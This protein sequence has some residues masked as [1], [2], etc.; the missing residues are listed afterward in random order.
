[1]KSA[2]KM[3]RWMGVVCVLWTT[4]AQAVT[5]AYRNDVFSYDPPS[6]A[7]QTVTWHTTNVPGSACFGGELSELYRDSELYGHAI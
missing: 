1:M 6:V 5:Y 7:A 3:M 2:S 4:G